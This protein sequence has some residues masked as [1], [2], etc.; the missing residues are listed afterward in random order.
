MKHP[1]KSGAIHHIPRR[2][3][4]IEVHKLSVSVCVENSR[5]VTDWFH[6]PQADRITTTEV[7]VVVAIV[8]IEVHRLDQVISV[9]DDMNSK[10]INDVSDYIGGNRLRMS[11][12]SANRFLLFNRWRMGKSKRT[13]SPNPCS[14]S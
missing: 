4:V 9:F 10:W 13:E 7:R 8:P 6:V 14:E 1:L 3:I 5:K 11:I 2:N 12:G